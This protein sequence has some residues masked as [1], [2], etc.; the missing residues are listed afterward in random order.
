MVGIGAI[1]QQ[2]WLIAF[3]D[4]DRTYISTAILSIF[5]VA[6]A[7]QFLKTWKVSQQINTFKSSI[8]DNDLRN[9][10]SY[11]LPINKL[12]I[13]RDKDL[14][15]IAW[16]RHIVNILVMMGFVGTVL[17]FIIALSA[18]PE[19]GLSGQEGVEGIQNSIGLIVV[20][21]NIAL[22]TTLAGAV[23]GGII[24]YI[25]AV[26]IHTALYNYWADFIVKLG[27]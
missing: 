13:L 26:I 14:T 6:W 19:S 24:I 10:E 27:K 12:L 5:A 16:M 3:V 11:N 8:K 9:Y 2:G 1:H 22:Y 25:N 20:G 23:T 7:Y 21:M 4:N 17:G 18:V 15:K